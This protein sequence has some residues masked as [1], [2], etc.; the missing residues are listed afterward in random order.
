MVQRKNPGKPKEEHHFPNF[1]DSSPREVKD[2]PSLGM[3]GIEKQMSRALSPPLNA[4]LPV[5]SPPPTKKIGTR[6]FPIL[7]LSDTP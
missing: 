6:A 4:G 7:A 1:K 3:V 2:Q 5:N